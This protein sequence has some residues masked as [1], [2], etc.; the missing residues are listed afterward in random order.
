MLSALKIAYRVPK[1]PE[2][3]IEKRRKAW[4]EALLKER[5]KNEKEK[6]LEKLHAHYIAERK[7][8]GAEV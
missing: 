4:T 7:T 1:L 5:I 6:Q 8:I 2:D 3:T